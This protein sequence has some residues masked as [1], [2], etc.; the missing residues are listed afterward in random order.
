MIINK[1]SAIIVSSLTLFGLTS[2]NGN[3]I[4]ENKVTENTEDNLQIST[5]TIDT[6]ENVIN[7]NNEET[8][9]LGL[10]DYT[11]GLSSYPIIENIPLDKSPENKE[12]L[13]ELFTLSE[14]EKIAEDI[15][16]E[17]MNYLSENETYLTNEYEKYINSLENNYSNLETEYTNLLN[18][19][20]NYLDNNYQDET[21]K[22]DEVI[23][24]IPP[25][26]FEDTPQENENNNTN[27]NKFLTREEEINAIYEKALYNSAKNTNDYEPIQGQPQSTSKLILDEILENI[28]LQPYTYANNS[29]I[30]LNYGIDITEIEDYKLIHSKE[31]SSNYFEIF[32]FKPKNL[33]DQSLMNKLN[34]R[35]SSIL[36]S[37]NEHT[38]NEFKI[39]NNVLLLSIEDHI[40]F[41]F[42]KNSD[43]ILKLFE[44]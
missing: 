12:I 2:C 18:D 5:R 1:K 30:S 44:Q 29:F 40:L 25:P 10:Y 39:E 14:V 37:I 31:L 36:S 20:F 22:E 28:T 35:I 34:L 27:N 43:D 41:C 13:E 15:S 19:F 11:I 9:S 7:L 42:S 23:P 16:N 33:S 26:S 38:N 4:S 8:P 21:D 17:Y 3:T 6:N 24:N 32:I